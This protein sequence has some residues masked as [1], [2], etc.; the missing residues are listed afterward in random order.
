MSHF[1]AYAPFGLLTFGEEETD[2][3]TIYRTMI[4]AQS[5]AFAITGDSHVECTALAR[6]LMLASVRALLN[7]A[8]GQH[9]PLTTVDMLADVE[10]MYGIIPI[11]SQSEEDRRHIL[12]ARELISQGP[13]RTSLNTIFQK[14][15]GSAFVSVRAI[16]QSETVITPS[17]PGTVGAWADPSRPSKVFELTNGIAYTGTDI[18]FVYQHRGTD[19]GT[20]L[21]ANDSVCLQLENDG[22]A[23]NVTITSVS[24][25][26]GVLTATAG[27]VL[28]SHDYGASVTT[29]APII[30]SNQ[31]SLIFVLTPSAARDA[32]NRRDV[33]DILQRTLRGITTWSIIESTAP[34]LAGPWILGTSR[35]GI[36]PL[37]PTPLTTV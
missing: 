21:V 34:T 24:D 16:D 37:G 27:T 11:Y 36:T 2:A 8:N 31:R 1:G 12:A 25:A 15:L 22:L 30:S 20:R 13:K 29:Y 9:H 33:E 28:N 3:G 5:E 35:I 7:H 26:D 32:Q 17:T 6:S 23:E 19:D 14:L 4:G 10:G 18:E